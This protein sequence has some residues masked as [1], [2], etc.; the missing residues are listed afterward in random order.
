[1]P[2]KEFEDFL[3]QNVPMIDFSQLNIVHL[4]YDKCIIKVPFITQNKNHLNSMYFGSI[5]IG[6]EV[7]A[8]VLAAYQLKHDNLDSG[9]IFKDVAGNFIKRSEADTYFICS[10]SQVISDGIKEAA[11]TKERV[12]I[13]VN[14]IGVND[15]NNLED[16]VSEF[17]ITVSIKY[18]QV[19]K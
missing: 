9:I 4:D 18:K 1:M 14:V 15:L 11:K 6:T 2:I 19:S 10:D 3:K 7:A 17:K 5:I 8:G 13:T 12:N 16:K